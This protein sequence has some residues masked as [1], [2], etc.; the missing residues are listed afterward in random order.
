[1]F[2]TH[3]QLMT[4]GLT[5]QDDSLR[6]LAFKCWALCCVSVEPLA[7]QSS[8]K[9]FLLAL[10]REKNEKIK[11]IIFQALFDCIL[12]FELTTSNQIFKALCEQFVSKVVNSYS[13]KTR[14]LLT[15]GFCKCYASGRHQDSLVLGQLML[16]CSSDLFVPEKSIRDLI[17]RFFDWYVAH[18]TKLDI[19]NANQ[20]NLLSSFAND[21]E[22][23]SIF[24]DAFKRVV[25]TLLILDSTIEPLL[26]FY[27]RTVR[28]PIRLQQMSTFLIQQQLVKFTSAPLAKNTLDHIEDLIS[29]TPNSIKDEIIFNSTAVL[30]K[31]QNEQVKQKLTE[32]ITSIS[33]SGSTTMK[34]KRKLI[35]SEQVDQWDQLSL[36]IASSS[37]LG[38]PNKK[39]KIQSNVNIS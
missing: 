36:S 21:G 4:K 17:G 22:I 10:D 3:R 5:S 14:K 31:I 6:Y 35:S 37:S 39:P 33:S 28:D 7:E 9:L 29:T 26:I 8:T 23:S 34:R 38:H 2:E 16:K 20:Y 18:I 32:F 13:I 15:L 25:V 24:D 1:M 27:K 12:L 11:R 30:G 19:L